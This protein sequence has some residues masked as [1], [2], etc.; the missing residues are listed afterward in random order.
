MLVALLCL[1]F[2]LLLCSLLMPFMMAHEGQEGALPASGFPRKRV[3]EQGVP[4]QNHTAKLN[5]CKVNKDILTKW[6]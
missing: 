6:S 2:L 5:L 4:E 3:E 1:G